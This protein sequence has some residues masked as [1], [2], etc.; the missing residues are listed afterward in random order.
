MPSGACSA[1]NARCSLENSLRS[2]APP[3]ATSGTGVVG[4]PFSDAEQT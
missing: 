1:K 3:R 4:T 2:G